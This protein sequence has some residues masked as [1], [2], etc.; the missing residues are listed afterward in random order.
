LASVKLSD[1]LIISHLDHNVNSS[2][3]LSRA[4]GWNWLQG[5]K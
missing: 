3:T 1:E 5:M 2:D 4:G